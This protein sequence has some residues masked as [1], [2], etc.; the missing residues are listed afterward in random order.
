MQS[1]YRT[2]FRLTGEASNAEDLVQETY[3][4]AWR[5]FHR[6]EKG[7]NCK[8]WLFKIFFRLRNK[9]HRLWAKRKEVAIEEIPQSVF[10]V[11]SEVENRLHL[12]TLLEILETLP[13]HYRTVLVLADVE[14]L[15]YREIADSLNLTLGT[16]M[17]RLNRARGFLREKLE[18]QKKNSRS[19]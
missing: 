7:T 13:E 5:S 14:N 3:K 16:V 4:E 1:L 11:E 19:A 15:S 8:A 6:Y 18:E 2:A 17:S 9:Q 10:A 12:K